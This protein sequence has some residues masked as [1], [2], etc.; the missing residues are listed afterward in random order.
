MLA[1]RAT[2]AAF[3][4]AGFAGM[5]MDLADHDLDELD[6][7]GM[8]EFVN[9]FVVSAAAGP[10]GPVDPNA[11]GADD[12]TAAVT[13]DFSSSSVVPEG[14]HSCHVTG[15]DASTDKEDDAIHEEEPDA[16]PPPD[17][18]R[19]GSDFT[20]PDEDGYVH[21]AE[22]NRVCRIQRNKP[23]GRNT[24]TCFLHPSCQFL[25]NV[26]R[27][28]PDADYF[29]YLGEAPPVEPGMTVL[30]RRELRELR[31]AFG[32]SKWSAPVK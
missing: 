25:I 12:M 31:V 3:A 5:M 22:A 16:V 7:E 19:F 13:A 29:E 17:P 14:E 11:T 27:C 18:P 15:V 1:P 8:E 32:K 30:E 9:H 23:K 6:R 24:Y 28:P 21:D 4:D 10:A 26:P 20:A 2:F